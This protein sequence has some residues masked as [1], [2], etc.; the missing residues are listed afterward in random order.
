MLAFLL[1]SALLVW[2]LL[3]E[4]A[5][6][7]VFGGLRRGGSALAAVCRRW[8]GRWSSRAEVAATRTRKQGGRVAGALH[9]HRGVLVIA[10]ALLLVPALSILV[11]RRNVILEG[12]DAVQRPAVNPLVQELLRGERLTPPPPPPPEVFTT[13]EVEQ[14]RPMTASADRKWE[15]L[16]P[17]F[18]QKLLVVYKVMREQYGYE[19]VLVEGYR[20]PERQNRLAAQGADVTRARGGQSWHQYGLAADSAFLREGK[21][22]ISERDPWAMRGYQLYGQVAK[23]AGLTWGGDWRSIKDL[24]HVEQRRPGVMKR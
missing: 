19:M 4:Q 2:L 21:L 23:Q 6:D 9:A 17:E 13:A 3:F 12:F 7:R 5:R 16:D 10:V 22:V 20:S 15:R 18:T 1:V 11:L 8:L 24:M 14:V